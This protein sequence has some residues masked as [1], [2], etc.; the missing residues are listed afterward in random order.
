MCADRAPKRRA[1]DE[2]E[3]I[4]N[5]ITPNALPMYGDEEPRSLKRLKEKARKDPRQSKRPGTQSLFIIIIIYYL[6]YIYR[7]TN[8]SSRSWCTRWQQH[9]R[10]YQTGW[11]T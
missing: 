11:I 1:I 3:L 5:I 8:V 7:F 10:I 6:H 4:S 2:Q 9:T